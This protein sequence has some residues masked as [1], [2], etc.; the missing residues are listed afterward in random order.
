VRHHARDDDLPE[1]LTFETSRVTLAG[2]PQRVTTGMDNSPSFH[3]L[4]FLTN[5]ND[6]VEA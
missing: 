4:N 5:G 1:A 6:L 2:K 3:S